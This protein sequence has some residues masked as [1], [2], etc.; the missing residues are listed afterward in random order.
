[1]QAQPTAKQRNGPGTPEIVSCLLNYP[2]I[3]LIGINNQECKLLVIPSLEWT[4][5]KNKLPIY[6][7]K[8][9]RMTINLYGYNV[10]IDT[11]N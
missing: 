11:R 7:R 9:I 8:K 6:Y 5:F 10:I 3:K 2:G 1:M 4:S